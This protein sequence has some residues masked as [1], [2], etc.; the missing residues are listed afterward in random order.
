MR[1]N[2]VRL[3]SQ[4]DGVNTARNPDQGRRAPKPQ[5]PRRRA[6]WIVR[7]E[8]RT[9]CCGRVIESETEYRR[10]TCSCPERDE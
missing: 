7:H 5:P 6:E 10:V 9:P 1:R 2:A 3:E 8:L 4:E